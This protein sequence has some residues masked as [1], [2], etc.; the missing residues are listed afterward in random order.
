LTFA[1]ASLAAI[2]LPSTLSTSSLPTSTLDVQTK[3]VVSTT[4]PKESNKETKRS[5][6]KS[7]ALATLKTEIAPTIKKG[8]EGSTPVA[9]SADRASQIERAIHALVN[10]ER[11]TAGLPPLS[12]SDEIAS[13]AKSHSKDMLSNAYFAH[14]DL[15]GCSLSCRFDA[16]HYAYWSIGENI[17]MMQGFTVSPEET[18]EKIVDGWMQSEGHRANILKETY[19]TE[20]V[21]VATEGDSVYATE[22]LAKPR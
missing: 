2:S 5:Q 18:A 14:D 15:F 12:F 13:L 1:F 21:G 20:G 8:A 6:Q 3:A 11:Q 22:D 10:A 4:S 16:M 9:Q 7:K 17:Y 19:T